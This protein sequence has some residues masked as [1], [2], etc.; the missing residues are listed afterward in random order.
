M[1]ED[2]QLHEAERLIWHLGQVEKTFKLEKHKE[3]HDLL[4]HQALEGGS[5]CM[6]AVHKFK[7]D[8]KVFQTFKAEATLLLQGHVSRLRYNLCLGLLTARLMFW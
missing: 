4:L 2:T 6:Q 5:E 8:P 7:E 1:V 3:A